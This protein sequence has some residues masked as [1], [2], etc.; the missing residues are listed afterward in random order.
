MD[1]V[2][3]AG[4]DDFALMDAI[5]G[6][7]QGALAALYDRH[8]GVVLGACLRILR[9][10]GEA[11]EVTGDVFIEVWDRASRYDPARGH[12]VAYLLNLA[13][14]RAIDR[15]RSQGRRTRLFVEPEP[16]ERASDDDPLVDSMTAQMRAHLDRALAALAPG[17]KRAL[18]LAYFDGMSHSEI[19]SA[20][21]EPLGT[22]KTRIRQGLLRMRET[23]D[24]VYGEGAAS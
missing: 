16:R 4:E 22:V 6:R 21:G 2:S 15:L 24:A 20:L 13:R 18:E 1:S 7:D 17:Q 11:E 3:P 9:D 23:L 8:S 19:A 12:P 10:R 14:S 5:A